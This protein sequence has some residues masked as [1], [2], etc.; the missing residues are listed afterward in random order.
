[1]RGISNGQAMK[2]IK[3]KVLTGAGILLLLVSAL[4]AS[5]W[6]GVLNFAADVPHSKFVYSAIEMIRGRSVHVRAAS[7][8]VPVL[9]N[10][11]L[12]IKG[13][14]NYAAMCAQCHL[15][16]GQPG[17]ELSRGLYP[18]PPNLTK[19][20][21]DPAEAFWT[22]K[23]GIKASGMPAWGK[24][25]SDQD[26][27]SMV[28]FLQQLPKIDAAAYA[29]IVGSSA[30]HSHQGQGPANHVEPMGAHAMP[31]ATETKD[32]HEHKEGEGH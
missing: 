23:H 17:T 7:L 31:A 27:W 29:K 28:A 6:M 16:P 15:T 22:I 1:M 24:S 9:D 20:I 25:M 18:S 14:G 5:V 12:V 26:I 3:F 21:T 2:S 11:Q 8:K 13:A 30:G 19:K 4:V 10:Q 32:N